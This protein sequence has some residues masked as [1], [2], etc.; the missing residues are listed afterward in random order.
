MIGALT[1]FLLTLTMTAFDFQI[2]LSLKLYCKNVFWLLWM[3]L[4]KPCVWALEVLN[5]M[6]CVWTC[7]RFFYIIILVN[8]IVAYSNP[9]ILGKLV[10]NFFYFHFFK[11]VLQLALC[12]AMHLCYRGLDDSICFDPEKRCVDLEHP[13]TKKIRFCIPSS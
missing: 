1:L 4:T 5:T 6:S 9:E 10:F 13:I 12:Y 7:H 8:C 11:Y 2:A 3:Y